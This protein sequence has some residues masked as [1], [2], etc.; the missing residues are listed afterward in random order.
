MG[1]ANLARRRFF[2]WL[3][4]GQQGRG[5]D[6]QCSASLPLLALL[7]RTNICWQCRARGLCHPYILLWNCLLYI[8]WFQN[9]ETC[10]QRSTLRTSKHQTE[11]YT[12]WTAGSMVALS[13]CLKGRRELELIFSSWRGW[14]VERKQGLKMNSSQRV[15]TELGINRTAAVESGH[16]CNTHTHTHI[17][18]AT[19]QLCCNTTWPLQ[20]LLWLPVI[21]IKQMNAKH[22]KTP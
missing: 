5:C 15:E 21:N 2:C 6:R 17:T 1:K 19:L 3:T 7:A 18:P 12:D 8:W 10:V 4:L 13:I 9:K 11:I 22:T 20:G 14:R 16:P